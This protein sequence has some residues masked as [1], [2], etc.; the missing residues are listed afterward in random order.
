[1]TD[2]GEQMELEDQKT[3]E[4][5]THRIEPLTEADADEMNDL[6]TLNKPGP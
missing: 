6:A 3:S 5:N 4:L 2:E 1:M